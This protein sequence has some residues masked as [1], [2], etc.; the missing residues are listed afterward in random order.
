[1]SVIT[2]TPAD[3]VPS[4]GTVEPLAA[5][6]VIDAGE[7]VCNIDGVAYKADANHATAARSN[8]YG[9]ATTS[10][11]AIGQPVFVQ[12]TGTPT[13]GAVLEKG[14]PYF[15]SSTP[16]KLCLAS[17]VG[18]GDRACLVGFAITTSTLKL[19]RQY[20]GVTVAAHVAIETTQ[21][22]NGVNANEIQSVEVRYAT[23]GTFTLT[24]GGQTTTAL[25]YNINAAD[26]ETAIEALSNVT[27]ATVTG[28]GTTAAP[29]LV[30]FNDAFTNY[31]QMTANIASLL[32]V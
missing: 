8:V 19:A 13:V 23:G 28:S 12:R 18:G 22:G 26:L 15:Q 29:F 7:T 4:A 30:Q 6:E 10:A 21:Q 17:D 27:S 5:G 1:M 11:L 9:L 25:A 16:G 31:D 14:L 3:V 24:F 20:S 2:I 32:P